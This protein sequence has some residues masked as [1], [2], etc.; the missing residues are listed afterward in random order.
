MIMA[1]IILFHDFV[2]SLLKPKKTLKKIKA[3]VLKM[4]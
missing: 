1:H 4:P 2:K 3:K